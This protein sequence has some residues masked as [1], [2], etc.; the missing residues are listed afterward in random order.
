MPWVMAGQVLAVAA[1]AAA[2]L[3][4]GVATCM[5][6]YSPLDVLMPTLMMGRAWGYGVALGLSLL[7]SLLVCVA[8]PWLWRGANER[9]KRTAASN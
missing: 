2:M 7:A 4:A 3:L 5:A 9:A 6:L 8:V 1:L